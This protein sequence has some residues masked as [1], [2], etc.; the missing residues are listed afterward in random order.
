MMSAFA[1]VSTSFAVALLCAVLMGYAIQRGATC[2]VAAVEEVVNARK[3]TR[4]AAM[5]E[6]GLWVMGGV[7][8]ARVFGHL[9]MP[10]ANYEVGLATVSGGALL[11]LGAL[12][13]RACV[14]GAIAKLGSGKWAYCM[15]PVGFYLGCLTAG[16][17]LARP[18]QVASSSLL[19]DAELAV[20]VPLALYALWRGRS[21][22]GALRKG[23]VLRRIWAPHQATMVIGLA[24]VVMLLTAG[25]WAYTQVLADV[26]N[27]MITGLTFKLL[28]FA[29]LLSGAIAGGWTAGL[30]QPTMPAWRDV[31]RC[32]LGGMMMGIGSMLV[33]GSNDS[34][35]LL[36]LP[37]VQPF[38]LVA[39]ASMVVALFAGL[40][41]ERRLARA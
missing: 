28:L 25:N 4:L 37:L 22:V 38:A 27:G 18:L 19:F 35:I 17:R 2:M 24:F 12:V 9:A 1:I 6:A 14:F 7:L 36:G 3:L 34:L 20:L 33:P 10:P 21:V 41:I 31:L 40:L 39:L 23:D 26:A 11:G 15:T 32:L 30:I 8:V 16:P 5:L 13:N 29:G